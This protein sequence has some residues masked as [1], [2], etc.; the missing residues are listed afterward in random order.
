MVLSRYIRSPRSYLSSVAGKSTL[1][2]LERE[3]EKL[4]CRPPEDF[5][6]VAI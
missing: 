2:E 6:F 4:C 5:L 1:E 3:A